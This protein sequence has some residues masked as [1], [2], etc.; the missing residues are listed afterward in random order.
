M[1]LNSLKS[2]SKDAFYFGAS[3]IISRLVGFILIPVFTKYLTPEDYGIMTLLGFY[4]LFYSPISHM[5]FQGAMFRYVGFSKDLNEERSFMQTA[6]FTTI[7][8][9]SLISLL[10]YFCIDL[11]NLLLFDTTKYNHLLFIT[12]ITSYFTSLSQIFYSYLRVKRKVKL[13]FRLSLVNLFCSVFFNVMLIVYF[14]LGLTGAIYAL[15]ISSVFSFLLGLFFVNIK[16]NFKIH[17]NKLKKMARYG[18]PNVPAYLQAIIM[19]LFGQYYLGRNFSTENLGLYAIAWKFCLPLQL[20]MGIINNAWKAFKFD[21]FKNNKNNSTVLT[22]FPILMIFIYCVIFLLIVLWGGDFLILF[23]DI[24]FHSAAKYVPILALIPL[25]NAFYLTFGSYIAFGKSQTFQPFIAGIGLIFTIVLSL[26]F[27]PKYSI[28]GVGFSTASGWLIMSILAYFYGQYLFKIDF[29][30]FK[31]L[32][33]IVFIITSALFIAFTIQNNLMKFAVLSI[34]ILL[35]YSMF[36][37]Y[38]QLKKVLVNT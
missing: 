27:I 36:G 21:L 23:T 15:L 5:G 38:K 30:I 19:V 20:I 4:T 29:K 22:Y 7:I 12:L 8:I 10:A 17:K 13:I 3:S 28:Y 26:I 14:E 32:V 35:F 6:L 1:L 11:I 24:E 2:F 16:W 33:F 37:G 9:S 34:N 25:F 31:L 18:L